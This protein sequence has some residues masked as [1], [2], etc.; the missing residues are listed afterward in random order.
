MRAARVVN[1]GGHDMAQLARWAAK[2]GGAQ[3][4]AGKRLGGVMYL[5]THFTLE[6]FTVSETAARRGVD[7][8]PPPDIVARLRGTAQGLEVVRLRLGAPIIIMSGYRCGALNAEIGGAANSQHMVGEAADFICPRFGHPRS[9]ADA[10]ADS[11]IEYDQ[12]ILEFGRWV[13][14]SFADRPRRHALVIDH[15]GTR[16]MV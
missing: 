16:P 15:N 1:L 10:L 3:Y 5:P 9:I 6:E 14:I 12:L 2:H 4:S 11:G 8:T 13:H 7:N